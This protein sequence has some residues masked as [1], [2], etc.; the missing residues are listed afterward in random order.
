M[1]LDVHCYYGYQTVLFLWQHTCN[2]L[3]NLLLILLSFKSYS[4]NLHD[5]FLDFFDFFYLFYCHL[6]AI[7]S[8]FMIFFGD[9][10]MDFFY[11]R[12]YIDVIVVNQYSFY[13]NIHQYSAT[14]L[15]YSNA[16]KRIYYASS[17]TFQVT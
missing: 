2:I 1:H 13:S 10:G 16:T 7:Q 8:I 17:L 3:S 9:M 15:T 6:K 12:K 5:F 14:F 11:T 4:I